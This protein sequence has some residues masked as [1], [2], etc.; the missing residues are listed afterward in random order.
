MKKRVSRN[1][2]RVLH[3]PMQKEWF[4][5]VASGDKKE[6]YRITSDHWLARIN[7]PLINDVETGNNVV[8]CF[9]NGYSKNSPTQYRRLLRVSRRDESIHPEWGEDGYKGINHFVLS[10]GEECELVN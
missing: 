2:C 3:L 10:I 6:E 7:S 1:E 4:D 8:V 5:M 9:R